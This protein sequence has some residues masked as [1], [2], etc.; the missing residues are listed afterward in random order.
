M[1]KFAPI[2]IIGDS[3]RLTPH[4]GRTAA[5]TA[6]TVTMSEPYNVAADEMRCDGAAN[7]E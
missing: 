7:A 2:R 6:R 3:Q 1:M 4:A 5:F